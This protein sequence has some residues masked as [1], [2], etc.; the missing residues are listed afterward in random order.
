LFKNIDNLISPK[1][2]LNVVTADGKLRCFV[3]DNDAG[4]KKIAKTDLKKKTIKKQKTKS[5]KESSVLKRNYWIEFWD[6]TTEQWICVDPWTKEVD[7]PETIEKLVTLPIHY[8]IAVDNDF[9]VRDV[10]ARYASKYL[11]SEVRHLRV[12]QKW[13]DATLKLFRSKKRSRNRLEDVAIHDR[14]MSQP[15]PLNISDFKSHPL[16]V[17]KKDLLKF[18]AIYPPDQPPI[19]KVR[20]VEVYPR[21]CVYHLDGAAN[22]IKKAR[23]IKPGEEP[24]KIVKARPD[25]RIPKDERPTDKTLGLYGYWQTEPFVPPKVINGRIP[26]NEHGNLY[27]YKRSMLPEGCAYLQLD[28]IYGVAR[29]LGFECVPCV[30]GWEFHKNGN[31][32]IIDGCAVLEKDEA[33]LREAW[34]QEF[35]KKALRAR[36]VCP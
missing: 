25:I 11:Y 22:W 36:Q 18:E 35:E 24:Y 2:K 15:M 8:V 26:R 33:K 17:L 7:R 21:S 30:V 13:W 32:P 19:G 10:T 6:E 23:S 9:G 31:H 12:D 16:Y 20:N 34:S 28:G 1:T 3:G 14:L 4:V 29:R 5:L 27:L